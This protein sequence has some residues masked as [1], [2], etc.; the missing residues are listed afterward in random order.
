MV[1]S[2]NFKFSAQDASWQGRAS[3]E[4]VLLLVR[5]LMRIFC[6]AS[7]SALQMLVSLL[8][9]ATGTPFVIGA[10]LEIPERS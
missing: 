1:M 10:D 4:Q 7:G 6:S 8:S 9:G 5:R 3:V 2:N